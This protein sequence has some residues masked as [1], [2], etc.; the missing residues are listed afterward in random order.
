[1]SVHE[2]EY[3]EL[4]NELSKKDRDYFKKNRMYPTKEEYLIE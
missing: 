2:Q 4:E 1:L 3:L